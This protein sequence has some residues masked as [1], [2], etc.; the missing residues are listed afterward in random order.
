LGN[1]E[2][3]FFL[4]KTNAMQLKEDNKVNDWV[5]NKAKTTYVKISGDFLK[6]PFSMEAWTQR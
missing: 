3:D 6:C 5:K 4:F 1:L 2:E